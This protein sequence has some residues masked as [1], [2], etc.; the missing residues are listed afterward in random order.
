M[1]TIKPHKEMVLDLILGLNK[2]TIPYAD[3]IVGAPHPNL[4]ETSEGDTEVIVT[5]NRPEKY[6]GDQSFTYDRWDLQALFATV[7]IDTLNITVRADS[8]HDLITTLQIT[9]G[10]SVY[11]EDLVD[12]PVE[13]DGDTALV[14]LEATPLS[15]FFKGTILCEVTMPVT[16]P[17]SD[18]IRITR[19]SGL[20]Y[21]TQG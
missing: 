10:L 15:Y 18:L 2:K 9:Y 14:I 16:L 3:L 5:S 1:S 17:L 11:A 19:L 4:D 13:Y 8:V 20:N 6:Y 21:P 7:G 12:S